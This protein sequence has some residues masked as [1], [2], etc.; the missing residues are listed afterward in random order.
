MADFSGGESAFNF[1]VAYLQRVNELLYIAAEA[2]GQRDLR[3]WFDVLRV[4]Y[5]EVNIKFNAEEMKSLELLE[6]EIKKVFKEH[7]DINAGDYKELIIRGRT[8]K[9]P[10]YP[11]EREALYKLITSYEYK[12]K[13]L[14][15][16]YGMLLP[17]KKDPRFAIL[18]M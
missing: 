6:D 8:V 16:V 2:K 7:P 9:I 13:K 1:A 5:G 12:I 11:R 10:N 18:D 3:R 15:D 14:A 4:V 17:G